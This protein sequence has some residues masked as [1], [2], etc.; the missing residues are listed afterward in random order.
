MVQLHDAHVIAAWCYY[1]CRWFCGTSDTM[2]KV[3]QRSVLRQ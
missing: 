3:I 2:G 1:G